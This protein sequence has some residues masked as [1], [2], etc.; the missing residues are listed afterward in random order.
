MSISIIITFLNNWKMT[1]A[2]LTEVYKFLPDVYEVILADDG[3]T[4]QDVWDGI[5]WWRSKDLLPLTLIGSDQPTSFAANVN[6]GVSIST[7]DVVV[8][9]QNDV[10]ISG[11]FRD[12]I[13]SKVDG[14]SV[15]GKLLDR[16]TGWNTFN[17]ITVPYVEGWLICCLREVWDDIGGLD[18]S[19]VPYDAE[20]IDFS[21]KA[22]E[23]GYDLVNV[24]TSFLR[25]IGGQTIKYTPE[26]RKVTEK[27]IE[28]VKTK[29]E[30]K[31]E[32]IYG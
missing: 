2:R 9:T 31:L 29:W 19:I 15:V 12:L 3:S 32:K 21:I 6:R 24:E 11:D 17:G 1:H 5:D 7:G 26:R 30:G 10:M 14:H 27:N 13:R 20:D 18:E 23:K 22:K 4:D 25:H 8:V 28:Y 16:D